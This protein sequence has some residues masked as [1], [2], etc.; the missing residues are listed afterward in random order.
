MTKRKTKEEFL[1]EAYKVHNYGYDYRDVIYINNKI[2]VKIHCSNNHTFEQTPYA[3]VGL[4]Q[5]CPFCKGL[6]K[7][8]TD[9]F[10]KK[11]TKIH[12]GLYDYSL[13]IYNGARTKIKIIC[14]KHGVFEQ[15]A[16]NHT[17]S[18]QGCPTCGKEINGWTKTNFINLCKKN[19]K[20]YGIFYILRC[21][22]EREEFYKIGIT[23]RTIKERYRRKKDSGGYKYDIIYSL[24]LKPNIAW[25]T[26]E[27][28]KKKYISL[29][30]KPKNWF[31][32]ATECFNLELPIDEII[33][34]LK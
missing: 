12:K 20:G 18:V 2:K 4:K 17:N 31:P 34:N 9:A 33:N 16:R 21:F 22:N 19:N 1:Q 27:A 14:K 24:D 5:G 15:T 6:N 13:T 23:A 8:T 32:G 29:S 3:H 26:E 11:A 28:L 10:I 30:H 25:D 7:T